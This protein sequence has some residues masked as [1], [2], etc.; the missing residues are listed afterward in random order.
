MY[1]QICMYSHYWRFA[2][3]LPPLLMR[4]FA[5]QRPHLSTRL[6]SITRGPWQN[7]RT[8]DR[9]QHSTIESLPLLAPSKNVSEGS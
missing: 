1:Y 6:L 2:P 5:G 4:S 7:S 3:S 8:R 9:I